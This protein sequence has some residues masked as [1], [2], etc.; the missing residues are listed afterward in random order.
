MSHYFEWSWGAPHDV[1]VSQLRLGPVEFGVALWGVLRRVCRVE[2]NLV[3]CCESDL[4]VALSAL[5][6]KE[7]SPSVTHLTLLVSRSIT[8][9]T[10]RM[11]SDCWVTGRYF[12]P[13]SIPAQ[14]HRQPHSH[15]A[16]TLKLLARHAEAARQALRSCSSG[17]QKLLVRHACSGITTTRQEQQFFL[18]ERLIGLDFT[19]TCPSWYGVIINQGSFF[20]PPVRFRTAVERRRGSSR[21]AVSIKIS[22]PS[23]LVPSRPLKPLSTCHTICLV[24]LLYCPRFPLIALGV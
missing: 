23:P 24:L 8:S 6:K 12:A 2:S 1:G 20:S 7:F 18:L 3:L 4:S 11:E 21:L 19:V 5:K 22:R 13:A 14:P 16:R 17:A 15:M 10:S 9:A